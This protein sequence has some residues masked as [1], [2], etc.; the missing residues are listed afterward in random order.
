MHNLTLLFVLK[1]KFKKLK[2][3]FV[4][5]KVTLR[6]LKMFS[7]KHREEKSNEVFFFY[8]IFPLN[9]HI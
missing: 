2:L 4:I 5:S 1:K 6:F 3:E 8:L 7:L 9:T